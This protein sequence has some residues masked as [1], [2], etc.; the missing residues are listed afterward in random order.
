M[1]ADNYATEGER[2]EILDAVAEDEEKGYF[3]SAEIRVMI[4]KKLA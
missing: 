1:D 3:T 4:E 2:Q